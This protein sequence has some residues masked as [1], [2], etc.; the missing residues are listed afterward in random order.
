MNFHFYNRWN[1]GDSLV[2]LHFLRHLAIRYP[3]HGF[4]H[5]VKESYLGSSARRSRT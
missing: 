3:E 2:H 4:I 1:L 5:A